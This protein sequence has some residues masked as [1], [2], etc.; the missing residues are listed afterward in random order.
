M[1]EEARLFWYKRLLKYN[2]QN[3]FDKKLLTQ[4]NFAYTLALRDK[5]FNPL[6]DTVKFIG[7]RAVNTKNYSGYAYFYKMKKKGSPYNIYVG[8]LFPKDVKQV[9]P[10]TI[11]YT[12]KKALGKGDDEAELIDEM[13]ET[14]RG[15]N[16]KRMKSSYSYDY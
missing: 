2:V 16:R 6:E 10:L 15:K 5:E 9:M 3:N 12:E 8:G 14:I 13:I 7:R 4:D 11:L 1:S